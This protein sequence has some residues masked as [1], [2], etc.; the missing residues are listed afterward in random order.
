V[1]DKKKVEKK[2]ETAGSLDP[3]SRYAKRASEVQVL[4]L[5]IEEKKRPEA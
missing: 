4:W 3:A 5:W 1:K 2:R